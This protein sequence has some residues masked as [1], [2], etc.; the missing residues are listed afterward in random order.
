MDRKLTRIYLNDH[1]ALL[2]LLAEVA[3][4]S[5]SSNRGTPLGARLLELRDKLVAERETVERAMKRLRLRRSRVKLALGR[6][7]QRIG[8]LKLNGRLV[9]YSP[10][11]R[12]FEL[13]SLLAGVEANRAVMESLRRL[14]DHRLRDL[15]FAAL[16]SEA[17]EQHD[18]LERFRLE[19]VSAALGS[20]S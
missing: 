15:D 1:L 14:D 12:V 9:S 4:R 17:S 3:A 5:A 7:G 13:E 2:A 16:A 8:A 19:A 6:L 10:L 20:A 18:E 11:S